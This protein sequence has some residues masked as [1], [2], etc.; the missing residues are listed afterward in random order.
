[1]QVWGVS[2]TGGVFLYKVSLLTHVTDDAGWEKS[3]RQTLGV[4]V[5]LLEYQRV[6]HI[7]E[8]A[9]NPD[10]LQWCE[11]V[12]VWKQR[13]RVQPRSALKWLW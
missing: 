8:M 2:V 10:Y 5:K 7:Q 12:M 6:W 13:L 11:Q 3:S 4:S 1:M 9:K